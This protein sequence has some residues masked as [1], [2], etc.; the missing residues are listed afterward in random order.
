MAGQRPLRRGCGHFVD[1]PHLA[2]NQRAL[3]VIRGT[4]VGNLELLPLVRD[5]VVF[6]EALAISSL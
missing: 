4:A 1:E 2:T 6:V 3:E 5:G